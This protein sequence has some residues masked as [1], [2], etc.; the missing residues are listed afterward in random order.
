MTTTV[1]LMKKL[2]EKEYAY[3]LKKIRIENLYKRRNQRLKEEKKRYGK[4][5]ELPSTSKLMA[6]YLFIIL[7]IVLIYAMVTM[8]LFRDLSYL[9]VLITDIASQIIT[10]LIYMKKATKE[11]IVGGI[12]YDMAMKQYDSQQENDDNEAVG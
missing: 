7:N 11:N 5:I 2:N 4:K 1:N 3:E 9:G 6:V 10:Y 12:T 8:Y